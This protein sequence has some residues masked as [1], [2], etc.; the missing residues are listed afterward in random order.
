R[1]VVL[2]G[3]PFRVDEVA[4]VTGHGPQEFEAQETGLLVDGV[5]PG[6]EPLLQLGAR[7]LGY[8]DRVDLHNSHTGYGSRDGRVRAAQRLYRSGCRCSFAGS[9]V[10]RNQSSKN[11]SS[12]SPAMRSVNSSNCSQ[13]A[14]PF[15]YSA[16][17]SR[18]SR[19]NASSPMRSRNACTASGPLL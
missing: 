12:S 16:G 15:A 18:S 4:V 19:S 6:G 8:G 5:Q 14:L 11:A 13:L 2:L 1:L 7:T 3:L 9:S 10:P 17:H